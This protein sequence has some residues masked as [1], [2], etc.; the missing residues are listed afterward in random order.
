MRRPTVKTQSEFSK[1]KAWPFLTRLARTE[2]G[3]SLT[4]LSQATPHPVPLVPSEVSPSPSTIPEDV[5]D[6]FRNYCTHSKENFLVFENES[7]ELAKEF[8]MQD[9]VKTIA[10]PQLLNSCYSAVAEVEKTQLLL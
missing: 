4:R 7:K 10:I 2:M 6:Q 1:A 5:K 8:N 9:V 3:N